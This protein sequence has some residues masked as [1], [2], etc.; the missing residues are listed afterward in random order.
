MTG[1]SKFHCL[2]GSIAFDNVHCTIR[3]QRQSSD[4]IAALYSLPVVTPC[5][6]LHDWLWNR[7]D[8]TPTKAG[9]KFPEN[10]VNFAKYRNRLHATPMR[11]RWPPPPTFRSGERKRRY[12]RN[13]WILISY[14][15]V[16]M[17]GRS[18]FANTQLLGIEATWSRHESIPLYT[19]HTG[20]S[21]MCK[22]CALIAGEKFYKKHRAWELSA[23]D[24]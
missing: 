17:T 2:P 21:N 4:A 18:I 3:S 23:C 24:I 14:K 20:T 1:K 5:C 9:R 8:P 10:W 22:P 13:R 7:P 16:L 12:F 6:Q 11:E 15:H 19:G